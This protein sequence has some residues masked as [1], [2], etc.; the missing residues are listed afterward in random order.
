MSAF[1]EIYN[2]YESANTQLREIDATVAVLGDLRKWNQLVEKVEDELERNEIDAAH[3]D[4]LVA[5]SIV[6]NL[7][8][9]TPSLRVFSKMGEQMD[10]L[11]ESIKTAFV[12]AW[13]QII[14]IHADTE[15]IVLTVSKN[16]ERTLE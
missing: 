11:T 9:R 1:S 14:S 8:T 3:V 7:Q 5:S 15:E 13:D 16:E 10:L 12:K 4:L 6:S 2:D